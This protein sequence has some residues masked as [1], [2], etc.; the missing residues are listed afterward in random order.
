MGLNQRIIT[1]HTLLGDVSI[2]VKDSQGRPKQQ[3]NNQ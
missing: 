3:T 2:R 1:A